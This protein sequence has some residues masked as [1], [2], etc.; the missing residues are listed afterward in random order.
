MRSDIYFNVGSWF[1]GNVLVK[2]YF[3][4]QWEVGEVVIVLGETLFLSLCLIGRWCTMIK[5]QGISLLFFGPTHQ[6]WKS[7]KELRLAFPFP[8]PNGHTFYRVLTSGIKKW[9]QT[10]FSICWRCLWL[11]APLDFFLSTACVVSQGG[12]SEWRGHSSL[13]FENLKQVEISKNHSGVDACV[14][15]WDKLHYYWIN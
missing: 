13:I 3:N 5:L 6:P 11:K 15:I 10:T 8:L 12:A 14:K 1:L 2:P 7:A 9:L 4:T